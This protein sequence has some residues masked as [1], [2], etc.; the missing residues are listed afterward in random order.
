MR[1]HFGIKPI[2]WIT[3]QLC[4]STSFLEEERTALLFHMSKIQSLQDSKERQI[5]PQVIQLSSK[6]KNKIKWK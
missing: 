5:G 6:S 3:A 1:Y 4:S 2:S